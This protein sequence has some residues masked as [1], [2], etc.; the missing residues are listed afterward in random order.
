MG[1]SS[2]FHPSA[3]AFDDFS[4]PFVELL[5]IFYLGRSQQWLLRQD[6]MCADVERK[7]IFMCEALQYIQGGQ[8]HLST[9][10]P[11]RAQKEA[12]ERLLARAW[13]DNPWSDFKLKE[14]I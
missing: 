6:H 7:W 2:L 14:L 3:K 13:S 10:H 1:L 5:L 4:L 11:S 12:G 8:V 9:P